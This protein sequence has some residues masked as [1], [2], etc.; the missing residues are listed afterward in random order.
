[1]K[2]LIFVYRSEKLGKTQAL[3]LIWCLAQYSSWAQNIGVTSELARNLKTQTFIPDI[4]KK[5]S[6]GQITQFT[7]HIKIWEIASNSPWLFYLRNKHN[8]LCMMYCVWC[9]SLVL[10]HLVGFNQWELPAGDFSGWL[11]VLTVY[12]GGSCERQ[13]NLQGYE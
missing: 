1:M 2:A 6:A 8:L 10:W 9:C 13:E 4:L 12:H 5:I 11:Q 3:P 7:V